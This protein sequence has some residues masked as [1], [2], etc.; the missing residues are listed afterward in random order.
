M[1]GANKMTYTE[2]NAHF[3]WGVS[4]PDGWSLFDTKKDPAC[5]NDL[6]TENAELVSTL[7]AAYDSWWDEVYP[8]M[9]RYGGDQGRFRP[10]PDSWIR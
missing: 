9:I 8:E 10:I 6:A 4:S 7:S 2:E 3:H 1:E 5:M